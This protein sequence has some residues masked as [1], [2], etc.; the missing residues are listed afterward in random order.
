MDPLPFTVAVGIL[1]IIDRLLYNITMDIEGIG[2]LEMDM[3]SSAAS[4]VVMYLG[5]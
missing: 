5:K 3:T 2:E 4:S 1:L